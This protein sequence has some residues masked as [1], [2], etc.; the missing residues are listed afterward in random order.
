MNKHAI[1]VDSP[2]CIGCGLC[3]T[4][5]P[6]GNIAIRDKR[7]V[8]LT[9]DCIQC[10]HCV[11]I[12]PREAVSMTGFDD[13]PIPMKGQVR[14]DPQQLLEALRTRR[15]IRQ[16]TKEPAPPQVI[17]QIIQ[18][19]R[20]TPTGKNAQDVS[21]LVLQEGKEKYEA[22]AVRLFKRLL[23]FAGLFSPAARR[24]EIDEHFFFK[25]APAVILVLSRDRT[26]GALAA[27]NMALMAEAL[28]LGVLY[29]GFF[30]LAV[31]HSR[32]LRRALG[33]ERGRRA[34][35]A[36]VLGYPGVTYRRT[37]QREEA[38]VGYL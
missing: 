3:Q 28:G 15:S 24:L 7:A 29:S 18:A 30:A 9:Q 37:A 38:K 35:A 2:R 10:G 12:C 25:Q 17:A 16:F 34:A 36:L 14:L 27:A 20:L 4:D 11:A 6:A 31:N 19:G 1:V 22:L 8:I 21:Y 5:C 33:V 32:K 26:N 23:P 13:P